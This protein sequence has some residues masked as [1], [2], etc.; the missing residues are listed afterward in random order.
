MRSTRFGRCVRL[1]LD[2]HLFCAVNR[3]LEARSFDFRSGRAL[4]EFD[5]REYLF[6]ARALDLFLH[7]HNDRTFFPALIRRLIEQKIDVFHFHHFWSV[8]TDLIIQLM[9]CFPRAKF[10]LT[11]HEL[12]AICLRDG[13]MVRTKTN[14]LC[15]RQS[16]IECHMCFPQFDKDQFRARRLF[17][18]E[19]LTKI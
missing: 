11:L 4:I 19:F 13:Q 6:P 18:Q 15:I 7:A 2:A 16:D 3:G 5:E 10:V 8:G 12:L 1:G 17:L 14:D 9:A